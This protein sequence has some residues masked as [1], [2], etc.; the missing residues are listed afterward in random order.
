M[1]NHYTIGERRFSVRNENGRDGPG[2]FQSFHV[3]AYE[4]PLVEPQV[5]HL[6]QVPLRTIV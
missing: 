1:P 5:S 3:A 4:H 2:R 6:R